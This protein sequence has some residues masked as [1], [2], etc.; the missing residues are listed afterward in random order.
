MRRTHAESGQIM[1]AYGASPNPPPTQ[2][3]L[4]APPL[5]PDVPQTVYDHC[6]FCVRIELLAGAL[7]IEYDRV[8]YGYGEGA[9]PTKCGGTGYGVGP[10]AL[11]GKK[12]LPVITGAGVPKGG[13]RYPHA[14]TP[15]STLPHPTPLH[16]TPLHPLSCASAP[17][18]YLTLRSS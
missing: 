10:V 6:P 7:G 14:P 13:E 3:P 16:S 11:T 18:W 5:I 4:H 9:D 2:S 15:R 12:M 1:N 17:P 8:V